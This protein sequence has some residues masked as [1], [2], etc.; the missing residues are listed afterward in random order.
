MIKVNV[1]IIGAGISGLTLAHELEKQ[2]KSTLIIEKSK[3]V[4]GRIASRR[5]INGSVNL[6]VCSFQATES[7][8]LKELA[9][10][11]VQENFLQKSG[12]WYV[13]KSGLNEW[14]KK[15]AKGLNIKR[16][17]SVKRFQNSPDGFLL[18]DTSNELIC[19]AEKIVI[20]APAPQSASLLDQSGIDASFLSLVSYSSSIKFFLVA[21]D[22]SLLSDLEVEF[23]KFDDDGHVLASEMKIE[24]AENMLD[25]TKEEITSHMEGKWRFSERCQEAYL[26]K[27]KYSQVT[28]PIPSQFQFLKEQDIFLAG[29]Y[30]GTNGLDSS[31]SSIT[32]VLSV[33]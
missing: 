14:P 13:A 7:L 25:L 4:G 6:G 23:H 33:I 16:V 32:N 19:L 24:F 8:K 10:A 3:G 30:F 9:E 18:Y 12:D 29:D 28:N 17:C 21:P 20:T 5:L 31:I 27:W 15:L 11:A 2:K 26:H 1:A 22:K